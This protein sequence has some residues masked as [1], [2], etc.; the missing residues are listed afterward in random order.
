M[1]GDQELLT[2]NLLT[3]ANHLVNDGV[4]KRMPIFGAALNFEL[5]I[6]AV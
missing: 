1:L 3:A 2:Q 6:D 5:Y 4:A